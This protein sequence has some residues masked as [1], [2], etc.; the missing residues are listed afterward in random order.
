[1]GGVY[2]FLQSAEPLEKRF[3]LPHR[4]GFLRQS[5]MQIYGHKNKHERQGHPSG[6]A[7]SEK[8]SGSCHQPVGCCCLPCAPA[9]AYAASS[10]RWRNF[11]FLTLAG[12]QVLPA[13]KRKAFASQPTGSGDSEVPKET[14]LKQMQFLWKIILWGE[15]PGLAGSAEARGDCFSRSTGTHVPTKRK[16]KQDRE[17]GRG[18]GSLDPSL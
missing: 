4:A 12:S 10:S 7:H 17:P 13:T 3:S 8:S 1:M 2:L 14:S 6:A 18:Q 15:S 11:P 9:S 5:S 16:L